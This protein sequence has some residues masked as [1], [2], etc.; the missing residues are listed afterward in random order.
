MWFN[1]VLGEALEKTGLC[2]YLPH[3]DTNQKGTAG[4]I[5]GQDLAGI[6]SSRTILALAENESPNWGAEVGYAWALGIPVIGLARQDHA[7]PL[8]LAGMIPH[9]L[10]VQNLDAIDSYLDSLHGMI[11]K[12]LQS[13]K[14]DSC[15]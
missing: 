7:L 11:A 6:R 1:P 8:I 9:V 12:N 13:E 15:C 3:R 14:Q 10:R 2:C 5:F 4:E